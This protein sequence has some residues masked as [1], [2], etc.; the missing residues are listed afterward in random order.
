VSNNLEWKYTYDN[1]NHLTRA[2]EW[3]VSPS[4]LL[5]EVDYKYDVFG[6]RVEADVDP[7]GDGDTDA[8][9]R[10]ALDGWQSGRMPASNTDWNVWAELDGQN[11]NALLTRYLRGDV[12]DQLFARQDGSGNAYWTLTDRL[13]SVRDVTDNTGVVKDTL[14]YDAYGNITSET[15]SASRGNY[16]WTGREFDTT[17][18]LQYNRARYYDPKSGRWL[19]QDPEG[20]RP[21]DS[22]LYRYVKNAPANWVDPSGAFWF[23]PGSFQYKYEVNPHW[24]GAPDGLT[25]SGGGML[26]ITKSADVTQIKINDQGMTVPADVPPIKGGVY[27][28]YSCPIR[29]RPR[30]DASTVKWIQLVS[31]ELQQLYL[32]KQKSVV[33][34]ILEGG[35]PLRILNPNVPIT[36]TSGVKNQFWF[37]DAPPGSLLYP[38]AKSNVPTVGVS[39]MADDPTAPDG[40]LTKPGVKEQLEKLFA[41]ARADQEA[42][43]G[44]THVADMVWLHYVSVA[45]RVDVSFHRE[46]SHS[47]HSN[48]PC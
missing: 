45:V 43:K 27:V 24:K 31:V 3:K 36:R 17:T 48:R 44:Y 9:T 8:I 11:S 42:T 38:A 4:T 37:V 35:Q 19:E 47:I 20:F 1:G 12:V 7:E 34:S 23:Q 25:V 2:Q 16:A 33:T 46:Q 30:E 5:Y 26:R 10:Y 22:N 32:S 18:G 13:G 40:Y 41:I 6:N 29:S 15:A 39:W 21:G 28:Q 14:S